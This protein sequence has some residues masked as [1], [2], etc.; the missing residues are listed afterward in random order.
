MLDEVQKNLKTAYN[1]LCY[2]DHPLCYT[3]LAMVRDEMCNIRD[4][5][6]NEITKH[7][8]QGQVD[9]ILKI[10]EPLETLD[11]VFHY[12]DLPCPRLLL[13]LGAPGNCHCLAIC[14]CCNCI[15]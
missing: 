15:V 13:V 7:T 10:K 11:D 1:R 6:L 3:Q 9:E 8:L 12:N 14:V 4:Q 5:K 2:S